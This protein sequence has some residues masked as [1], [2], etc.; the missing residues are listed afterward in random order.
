SARAAMLHT[1]AEA[2]DR[3]ENFRRRHQEWMQAR[4]QATLEIA[5]IEAQMQVLE[6]QARATTLQLNQARVA[7]DQ[8][9][10]SYDFLRTRFSN[11]Q[12]YQWLNG[13]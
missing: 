12:L 10:A 2:T 6:A 13:Q 1:I 8:A 4:D 9:L 3:A 7:Q 5:Q 11:A